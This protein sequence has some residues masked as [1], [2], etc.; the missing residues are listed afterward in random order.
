MYSS[1]LVEGILDIKKSYGDVLIKYLY[2]DGILIQ[3]TQNNFSSHY[4]IEK[5]NDLD[6]VSLEFNLRGNY[7]IRHVGNVYKT[8]SPQ[9]N[10]I[11]TKD[12]H[13]TFENAELLGETF[14]IQFALPVFLRMVED[15]NDT[16]KRF[17][18]KL[19]TGQPVVISQHSLTINFKLQQAIHEFL[20]CKFSGGLK[21]LFL[22]SKCIE[23]LVLQAEA[24]H[25]KESN[26]Q[27]YF[28]RAED[29][30]R[31][32]YAKE[33]LIQHVENPPSL[34]QLSKIIGL[35][36]YKLKRGFKEIFKTTV[37][38]Y[39]SDYRLDMAKQYLLNNDKPVSE[40]AYALGYSSPQH[41]SNAF[42]KKFGVPPKLAKL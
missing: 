16:L 40:V 23:I 8:K 25:Q 29:E 18:D 20:N 14:K 27:K 15:S 22:L 7:I 6:V 19:L 21:K 17:T 12:F 42:K 5:R 1:E 38:G 28:K 41:F 24:Y 33:Y 35:N 26:Q 13:N 9:H 10:I 34:S 32:V 4:Q 31:I 11:Y 30:D 2:F 39:L 37:F 36:E 3:H